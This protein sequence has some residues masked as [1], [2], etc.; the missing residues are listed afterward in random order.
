MKGWEVLSYCLWFMSKDGLF[1]DERK[2]Q[3]ENTISEVTEGNCGRADEWED[4]TQ[5]FEKGKE[6]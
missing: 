3:E 1:L 4:M 6:N 2:S 5:P